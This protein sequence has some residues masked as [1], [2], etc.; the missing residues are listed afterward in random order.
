MDSSVP[1]CFVQRDRPRARSL[2]LPID[3]H[4]HCNALRSHPVEGATRQIKTGSQHPTVA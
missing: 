3:A 2:P 1:Y 4:R